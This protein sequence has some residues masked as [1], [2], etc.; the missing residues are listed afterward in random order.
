MSSAIA[1]CVR[2]P[3]MTTKV[4]VAASTKARTAFVSNA[5]IKKTT[6]FQVS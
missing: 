4:N 2:A 1:S 5:T 3:V 6:A